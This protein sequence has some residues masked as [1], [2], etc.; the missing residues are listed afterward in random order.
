MSNSIYSTY[1]ASVERIL[2]ETREKF[3]IEAARF[4]AEALLPYCSR[5]RLEYVAGNGET[6][7]FDPR[8]NRVTSVERPGLKR[9]E[10]V[11]NL[12]GVDGSDCFGYHVEDIRATDWIVG[13][14]PPRR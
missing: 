7:F 12:P 10:D 14:V 1:S 3:R 2:D 13:S 11:L 5:M 8:G 4:R 9:F 6:M